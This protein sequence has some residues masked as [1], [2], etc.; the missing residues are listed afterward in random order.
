MSGNASASIMVIGA[1]S[2]FSYLLRRYVRTSAHHIVFANPG[3]DVLTLAQY[4]QPVAIVLGAGIPETLCRAMVHALKADQATHQ[5]PVI[6]CFW[7]EEDPAE[8]ITGADLYLRMPILCEDFEAAL[9]RVG[10]L[11][12]V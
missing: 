11:I 10:V 9:A 2:H 7:Q 3:E 1:D 12:G 6:L 5:I 8:R 4:T